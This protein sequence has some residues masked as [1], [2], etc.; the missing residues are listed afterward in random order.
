MFRAEFR[1]ISHGRSL[2]FRRLSDDFEASC[3][4]LRDEHRFFPDRVQPIA[5][6]ADN[7]IAGLVG[8]VLDL[9]QAFLTDRA[10]TDAQ[11]SPAVRV[12]TFAPL[13]KYRR[14]PCFPLSLLE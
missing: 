2:T 9:D 3:Q 4:T 14:F 12:L 11:N 1:L 13:E 6:R 10:E 8:H 5:R 7:V